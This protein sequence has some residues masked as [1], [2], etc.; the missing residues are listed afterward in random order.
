MKAIAAMDYNQKEKIIL[1]CNKIIEFSLY[2]MVF[3]I[4]ISKAI[5]E[6]T[7][8]IAIASFLTKKIIQRQ[9]PYT[10]INLPLFAFI[11]V[12]ALS[13]PGTDILYTALRNFLCK[14]IEQ[15]LLF[16]IV[17]DTINTKRKI[18]NILWIMLGSATL[19]GIDGIF[20][21][22]TH[23][24]FLRQRTMPF[25]NRINASFY[26]PN[27]LGAFLVPLVILSLSVNTLKFKNRTLNLFIKIVNLLLLVNLIL[28]FSRG[29]WF[30]LVLGLL[31][32]A[33]ISVLSKNKKIAK[34]SL[35]SLLLIFIILAFLPLRSDI[36][37]N[38]IFAFSDAGS[39]D[40]RGL[41]IIAWN[42]IKARPLLGHGI[43]T[44]MHN[45]KKYNTIGYQHGVS[46]AH[47]CYLQM[48]AEIGVIGILMFFWIITRLFKKS[49]DIIA[50]NKVTL[51]PLLPGLVSSLAAFLIHSSVDTNL[52]SL[53]LG[54]LFWIIV[55]LV[56]ST[57]NYQNKF[58][59]V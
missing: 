49:I 28:T 48:V 47:N 26:T 29:A 3:F 6:I 35:V 5:I 12:S 1:L 57:L 39:V 53:D 31:F 20:Q 15:V 54:T 45:F 27:D 10:F 38:K 56:V 7:S 24:D 8:G 33:S 25:K 17:F 36:P 50:N 22:F 32:M 46:Y 13:I 52:Y 34:V 21:H 14:L 40:R 11:I 19:V 43:G 58:G 42:M 4:P 2:L 18:R 51:D 37:L 16:F 59:Y 9:F 30:S 23:R 44:F 41:W 55:A